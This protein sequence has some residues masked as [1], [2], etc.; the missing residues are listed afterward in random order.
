MLRTEAEKQGEELNRTRGKVISNFAYLEDMISDFIA[1]SYFKEDEP[2]QLQALK[3]EVLEDKFFS[4]EFKKQL[5]KKILKTRFKNVDQKFPYSQ[6]DQLQ[7]FR[8]VIAHGLLVGIGNTS[9]PS[10]IYKVSLKHGGKMYPVDETLVQYE[11]L[12]LQVQ[13]SL[14]NLPGI[15]R[16]RF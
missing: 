4:F 3:E 2:E 5:L 14:D 7:T 6:L 12:R 16:H 15:S 8:N 13:P 9:S 10:K 11:N 1:A